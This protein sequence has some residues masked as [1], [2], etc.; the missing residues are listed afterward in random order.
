MERIL[1]TAVCYSRKKDATLNDRVEFSLPSDLK[2]FTTEIAPGPWTMRGVASTVKLK[3]RLIDQNFRFELTFE[4]IDIGV[5]FYALISDLH[6]E[7]WLPD[8]PVVAC[9]SSSS[10]EQ[11]MGY[12]FYVLLDPPQE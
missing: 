11:A 6:L 2:T 12:P 3:D 10:L 7:L 4:F 9:L 1:H 5:R 8:F